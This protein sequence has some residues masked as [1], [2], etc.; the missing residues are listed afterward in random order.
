MERNVHHAAP[1]HDTSTD[2]LSSQ[3]LT[4]R[5]LPMATPHPLVNFSTERSAALSETADAEEVELPGLLDGMSE[6]IDEDD[7]EAVRSMVTRDED[8][9]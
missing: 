4:L 3:A 7:A 1:G 6:S 8:G 5:F 9:T 2:L